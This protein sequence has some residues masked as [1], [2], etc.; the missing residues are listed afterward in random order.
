MATVTGAAAC[1]GAAVPVPTDSQAPTVAAP[2]SSSTSQH[3]GHNAAVPSFLRYPC[4][5]CMPSPR[6]GYECVHVETLVEYMKQCAGV[7]KWRVAAKTSPKSGMRPTCYTWR[8]CQG[9]AA[10]SPHL[11]SWTPRW[12]AR[13][14]FWGR[15]QSC[16]LGPA[17]GLV[18]RR[19]A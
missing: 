17:V 15:V 18:L 4:L 2:T 7:V 1:F 14:T 5:L 11:A 19:D 10:R 16:L 3:A 8:F 6:P 9:Y 12:E 13:P